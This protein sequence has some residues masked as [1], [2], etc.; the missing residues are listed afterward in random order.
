MNQELESV[1]QKKRA[2]VAAL[3]NHSY[4]NEEGRAQLEAG[5]Q[6]CIKEEEEIRQK[7]SAQSKEVE[8]A[9]ESIMHDFKVHDMVV[10]EEQV[11]QGH[12]RKIIELERKIRKA[13]EIIKKYETN[14]NEK[15]RHDYTNAIATK[16][17]LSSS[18]DELKRMR[19]QEIITDAKRKK[20]A[21]L[22]AKE[23][24]NRLSSVQKLKAK[25]QGNV[26]PDWSKLENN[27]D[28]TAYDLDMKYVDEGKTR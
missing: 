28:I 5:I 12:Y 4:A 27:P 15:D 21:Y 14:P 18:L 11:M 22:E 13:D 19:P 24:Y 9:R 7:Y 20:Q 25:V 10:N 2:M 1:R 17:S 16:T 6:M 26:L 3:E 23:R 8:Q